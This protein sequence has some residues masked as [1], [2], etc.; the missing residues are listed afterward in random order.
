MGSFILTPILAFFGV[1]GYAM[2]TA[3]PEAISIGSISASQWVEYNGYNSKTLSVML[4]SQLMAV[5]SVVKTKRGLKYTS[6]DKVRDKAVEVMADS[7]QIGKPIKAIQTTLGMIPL[8]VGGSVVENGKSIYLYLTAYASNGAVYKV[9]CSIPENDNI[10]A[11]MKDGV[12]A[13]LEQVDPFVVADYWFQTEKKGGDFTNT[14]RTIRDGLIKANKN[15]V[16]WYYDL[17]GQVFQAEGHYEQAILNYQQAL[18]VNPNLHRPHVHWAQT[19]IKLGKLKDAEHQLDVAKSLNPTDS[20]IYQIQGAVYQLEGEP[21]KAMNAYAEALKV[22]PLDADSYR[23]WALVLQAR[24]RIDDAVEAMRRA[25]YIDPK[26]KSFQNTLND[27]LTREDQS[28]K[29]LA[30]NVKQN[31]APKPDSTAKK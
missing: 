9:K 21:I 15:D 11:L 20:D 2:Y 26:N 27:I 1:F 8:Q 22:N 28:F 30:E 17:L 7:L 13:L 19:F 10:E 5:E 6:E 16:S 31:E 14:R 18:A 24:G 3:D 25:I 4:Q 23:D 29:D 12:L